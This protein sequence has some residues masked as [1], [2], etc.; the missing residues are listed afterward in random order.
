MIRD[1]DT[2]GN[3]KKSCIITNMPGARALTLCYNHMSVIEDW[4]D[5]L[6]KREK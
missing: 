5:R 6:N 1:D 3:N 2:L 4:F